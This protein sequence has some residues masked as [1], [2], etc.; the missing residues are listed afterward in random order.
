MIRV[1]LKKRAS[2]S[3]RKPEDEL[4]KCYRKSEKLSIEKMR[5]GGAYRG[6]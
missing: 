6:S 5:G 1:A 4:K 3:K 2:E